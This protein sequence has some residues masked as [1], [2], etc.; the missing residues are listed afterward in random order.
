MSLTALVQNWWM[1]AIR[2]VLAVS[3]GVALTVWPGLTLSN[4][5]VFFGLY[6]I[7]DGAWSIA[8]GLR[9]TRRVLDTWPVVL[10]G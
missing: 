10:E 3:L 4:V 5:V 1:M 7:I 2:G 9:A 6:A 8:A